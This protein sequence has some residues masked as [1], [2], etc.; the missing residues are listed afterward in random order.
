MMA[1]TKTDKIDSILAN[2][3]TMSAKIRYLNSQ[4]MSRGAI[5]KKLGIKYQWVRNVL[6]QKVTTPKEK[7][8][9]I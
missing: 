4:Q 6:E 7:I 9:Q 8:D 5:A 1:T 2:F 3:K